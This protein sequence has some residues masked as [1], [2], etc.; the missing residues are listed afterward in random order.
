MMYMAEK[1]TASQPWGLRLHI[2]ISTFIYVDDM[3]WQFEEKIET[4]THSHTHQHRVL[5][6]S[7]EKKGKGSFKDMRELE[8]KKV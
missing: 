7:K 3:V 5:I 6:A 4:T 1:L 2:C 8:L